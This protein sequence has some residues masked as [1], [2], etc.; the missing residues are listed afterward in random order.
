MIDS[1]NVP[2][3]PA[4]SP[5]PFSFLDPPPEPPELPA[6]I[7]T[8]WMD[9][10]SNTAED[11]FVELNESNR[12][13]HLILWRIR[14][15][16]ETHTAVREQDVLA[17]CDAD[18]VRR[19]APGN[20]A[21]QKKLQIVAMKRLLW[22]EHDKQLEEYSPPPPGRGRA[23]RLLKDPGDPMPVQLPAG[24]VTETEATGYQCWAC[25]AV[26]STFGRRASHA[27]LKHSWDHPDK[28]DVVTSAC[29][30]C[31]KRFSCVGSVAV[32]YANRTCLKPFYQSRGPAWSIG[33]VRM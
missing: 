6:S 16:A 32:H 24:Y 10:A 28:K 27:K 3:D 31:G 22:L 26:F 1:D 4:A 13:Q 8:Q 11:P 17:V 33:T 5:L 2:D 20:I 12:C 21:V 19:L 14:Q 29:P 9:G 30:L 23:E 25:P 18:V 7:A 15:G